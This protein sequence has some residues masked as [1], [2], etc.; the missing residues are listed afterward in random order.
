MPS[1][2]ATRY[3]TPAA[4][5]RS[6]RYH[7]GEMR[8]IRA[9]APDARKQPVPWI[10]ETRARQKIIEVPLTELFFLSPGKVSR[11]AFAAGGTP[12]R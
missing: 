8:A 7:R 2:G 12:Q 10:K 11:G 9:P 6:N 3:R 4:P 5:T 1:P